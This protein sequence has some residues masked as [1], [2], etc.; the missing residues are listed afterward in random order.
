[1]S[2]GDY[3]RVPGVPQLR[4]CVRPAVTART[5]ICVCYVGPVSALLGAGIATI[6]M[7]LTNRRGFDANG[8]RYTS[9]EHW[10]PRARNPQ[11]RYRIWRWMKRAR[12]LK[13]PGVSA[14]LMRAER[15]NSGSTTHSSRIASSSELNAATRKLSMPRLAGPTGAAKTEAARAR[16]V[17][18]VAAE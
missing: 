6:D 16:K 3:V 9:D 18:A 17:S 2:S 1:M 7:L 10:W 4:V 12:A 5:V 11:Q 14:A 8:D 13:M 15:R